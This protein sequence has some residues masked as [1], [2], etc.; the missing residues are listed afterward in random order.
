MLV[1]MPYTMLTMPSVGVA[2][3]QAVVNEK[4]K[5]QV[6]IDSVYCYLDF[7]EYVGFKQY[8]AIGHFENKGLL[9][10][11]FRQAAFEVPDNTESY[12]AFFYSDGTFPRKRKLF[13]QITEK[14]RGIHAFLDSLIERYRLREYPVVG[15]TSMMSQNIASFALA[16]RLKQ[17]DPKV[18]TVLGGPN[19]EHPM[20]K[21]IA[22]HVP[23][24]DYVFTGEALVNFPMFLQAYMAGD[25]SAVSSIRGIHTRTHVETRRVVGFSGPA[26]AGIPISVQNKTGGCGTSELED[27][28]GAAFNF[29]EMPMLDY[30]TYLERV[31]RSPLRDRLQ[32]ELIILF[33]TSTGCWW[34]DKVP[35]SFCGLTPH[36]FRQMSSAKAKSYLSE[37]IDRYKG[38]FATFSATDPCMPIEYPTEVFPHVNQDKAA[39]LQYE[40]KAKMPASDMIAMAQ[41]N[42]ILPQPGI[43]SLSTKTLKIMR[44]GVTAFHNVQFL[45]YCAEYGLYP[46]WNLLYG[47]PN[48]NYDELDT[49]KLVDDI[50][51][52]CHLPP[53]AAN[54]PISYQRY[55]EYFKDRDKYGLKLRPVDYY[56]Y[57]YPFSDHVIEDL[58]YF[59]TDEEFERSMSE[60]HAEVIRAINMEVV[61]WMYRF[62]EQ[63]PQLIFRDELSVFDSRFAKP[64]T[65]A[66]DRTEREVL[67]FLNEPHSAQDVAKEFALQEE[68]AHRLIARLSGLRLLFSE[69]D[70][71]LNVVCDQCSL[72]ADIYKNYYINFVKNSTAAFD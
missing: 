40:V 50:Q 41:A 55:S 8:D 37:L 36:A 30:S 47:F 56:G 16:R 26:F 19:A 72:T 5:D 44:K 23:H 13:D 9:D 62:R 15:F 49:L 21:T 2:Q 57:V 69:R 7:A 32:P 67:R 54:G 29:N 60:K 68:H 10:W 45:K 52:V 48:K 64:V 31:E 17:L 66:I 34:A 4:F 14:R 38:K 65:H 22:E 3:L 39:T 28:S 18:T 46:I 27:N 20:G 12:R 43:E 61:N 58:A 1:S 35:C 53:P 59:F 63:I 71:Y 25:L 11:M 33:Q 51:T 70:K 6:K 24:I 42:V